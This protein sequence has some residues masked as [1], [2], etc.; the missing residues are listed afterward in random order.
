[1]KEINARTAKNQF[2]QLLESAQ[3]GPV[4]VTRRGRPAGVLL[5]EE[6]YQRL[7][8][9]AWDRL[10]NTVES[11]RQQASQQGLT[12]NQLAELLADDS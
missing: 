2:G 9:I 7:R 11:M 10:T 5:S 1:M 12:E 6:Q 3:R 8:G 4:R